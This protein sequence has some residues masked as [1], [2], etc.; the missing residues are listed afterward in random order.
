MVNQ[1]PVALVQEAG[2]TNWWQGRGPL[3]SNIHLL[4]E[5]EAADPDDHTAL[6]LISDAEIPTGLRQRWPGRLVV[7][8]P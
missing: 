1:E 3:P 7:Y 8:R 6:L 2:A 4:D 5:L